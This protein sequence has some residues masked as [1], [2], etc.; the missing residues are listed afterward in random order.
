[1]KFCSRDPAA[2]LPPVCNAAGQACGSNNLGVC[3][4]G[5]PAGA[6]A[7]LFCVYPSC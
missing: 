5:A 4:S 3:M 1:M 7:A 2:T 6:P